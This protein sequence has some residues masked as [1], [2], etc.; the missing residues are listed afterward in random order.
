MRRHE[1]EFNEIDAEF[2]LR[3]LHNHYRGAY[4]CGLSEDDDLYI[5]LI[6]D[7]EKLEQTLRDEFGTE[8]GVRFVL[9]MA[10]HE[11]RRYGMI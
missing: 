5:E 9:E 2:K 10:W 3:V 1:Y 6:N 8:R 11:Y 4:E 7:P